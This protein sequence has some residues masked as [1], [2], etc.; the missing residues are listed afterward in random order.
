[1]SASTVANA[2]SSLSNTN[3]ERIIE[4]RVTAWQRITSGVRAA[5]PS[6][7]LSIV[8]VVVVASWAFVPDWWTSFDPIVGDG[9]VAKQPPSPEH[10]FGTDA[11]GRDVFSRVVHGAALSLQST[12]IA[13][14]VAFVFSTV[15]GLLAGFVGGWVD[16]VLMRVIDVLLSVPSLLISLL[17]VTALGFGTF[18][19]AIAVGVGS[20]AQFSRVM[21]AEVLKVRTSGFVEA[22]QGSGARWWSVLLRHVFPHAAAPILGLVALEF[23]GAILAIAALNFL[24]YGAQP[25]TPE[26]G[27]LIA[28]GRQYLATSW[29]MT[30]LPGLV[31]VAVVVSTNV[32]S[33]AL[34]GRRK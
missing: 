20:V 13:I 23:G 17:L 24:G 19:I 30:T 16:E 29:W 6:L 7:V 15:I 33:R 8:V 28:D 34:E 9:S 11:I 12:V 22:A 5:R 32:I 1:M 3:A 10:I 25:P 4:E 31:I 26:W 14:A 21:R 27:S 2:P 18:N